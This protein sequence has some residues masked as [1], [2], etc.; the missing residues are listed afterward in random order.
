MLQVSLWMRSK[1]PSSPRS[2]PSR[3]PRR[4]RRRASVTG[5]E[6][7]TSKFV[8]ADMQGRL[9]DVMCT[10]MAEAS[11]SRLHAFGLNDACLHVWYVAEG[12]PYERLS[13]NTRGSIARGTGHFKG[14]YWL[15]GVW[16]GEGTLRYIIKIRFTTPTCITFCQYQLFSVFFVWIRFVWLWQNQHASPPVTRDVFQF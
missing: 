3:S 7:D 5:A 14:W 10:L 6:I 4:I 11:A 15:A 12:G 2:S 9:A 8:P 16:N 13:R 1:A